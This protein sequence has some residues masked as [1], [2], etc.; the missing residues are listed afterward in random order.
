MKRWAAVTEASAV[1]SGVIS[2]MAGSVALSDCF[3]AETAILRR[4]ST[5]TSLRSERAQRTGT[6]RLMPISVSF[7]TS[8]SMR[9]MF[10]VG[11]TRTVSW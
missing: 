7:S 10:L 1:L 8:H 2:S 3:M 9:S 11:A 6:K 4:R 5:F